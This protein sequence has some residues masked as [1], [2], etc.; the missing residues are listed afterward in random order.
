M[1]LVGKL[2][3]ILRKEYPKDKAWKALIYWW[4]A[5]NGYFKTAEADL[6]TVDNSKRVGS[7]QSRTRFLAE[8]EEIAVSG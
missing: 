8:P 3:R 2:R 4:L 7:W 6:V 5:A 1:T